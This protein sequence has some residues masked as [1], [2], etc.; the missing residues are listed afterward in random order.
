MLKSYGFTTKSVDF[1]IKAVDFKPSLI[2][3][4]AK[5][6]GFI[7]KLYKF[8]VKS[9]VPMLKSYGFATKSVD[10]IIKATSVNSVM[11]GTNLMSYAFKVKS[12]NI[13]PISTDIKPMMFY[14][15][16]NAVALVIMLFSFKLMLSAFILMSIRNTFKLIVFSV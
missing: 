1:I 9:F 14:S 5:P 16:L 7:V 11:I 6:F 12:I 4:N 13:V 8:V 2:R 3:S 10:F 15:V